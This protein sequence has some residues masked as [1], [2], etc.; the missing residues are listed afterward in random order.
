MT[1]W[2]RRIA[3]VVVVVITLVVG[4]GFW[5]W[6]G[7]SQSDVPYPLTPISVLNVSDPLYISDATPLATL[8]VLVEM[9]ATDTPTLTIT[10]LPSSSIVAPHWA[11]GRMIIECGPEELGP[12]IWLPLELWAE[13]PITAMLFIDWRIR[14]GTS[15]AEITNNIINGFESPCSGIHEDFIYGWRDFASMGFTGTV[16]EE[17]RIRIVTYPLTATIY[18][19]NTSEIFKAEEQPFYIR[20]DNGELLEVSDWTFFRSFEWKGVYRIW[21]PLIIRKGS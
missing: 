4:I 10:S 6:Y 14:Q 9:Q 20:Q 2:Q 13:E 16:T 19:A 11:N 7:D 12:N 21:L 18:V 8:P 17:V 3:L 1:I 5:V 15:M